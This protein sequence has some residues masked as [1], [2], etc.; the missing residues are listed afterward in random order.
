[1]PI[2]R[3]KLKPDS[4]IYTALVC[5]LAD[6]ISGKSKNGPRIIEEEQFGHRLRVV[7]IWDDWEPI[8]PE[9]RGRAIMDAYRRAHSKPGV[10]TITTVLGLTPYEAVTLGI[11]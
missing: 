2:I 6:E 3:R 11:R 10:W 1:M 4:S 7:V 5:R 9:E 8:S